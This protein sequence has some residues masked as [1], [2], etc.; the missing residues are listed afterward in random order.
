MRAKHVDK[1]QKYSVFWT[2]HPRCGTEKERKLTV[3]TQLYLCINQL[4]VSAVYS[5]YKAEY[6]TI[7]KKSFFLFMALYSA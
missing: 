7:N 3:E 2:R 4:H 1:L 5:H 6:R